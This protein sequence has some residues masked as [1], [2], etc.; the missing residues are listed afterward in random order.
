MADHSY[1]F[2]FVNEVVLPGDIVAEK[3]KTKQ[4]VVKKIKLKLG[5][6]LRM[7][8]DNI[9]AYKC[10][11]LREKDS[12]MFWIDNDQKRYIPVKNDKVV[13]IVTNRGGE[14]Y[15]VDIGSSMASAL[16]FLAF[17]GATK[18][19]KPQ[20]KI[21]DLVYGRLS[22]ANKDME[23]ELVCTDTNGKANGM[24]PLKDGFLFTH[25]LGLTRKLLN[26]D[27]AVLKVLGKVFSFESTVGLNGRT[28]VNSNSSDHTILIVNAIEQ[29]EYMTLSQIKQN[30]H[31]LA[32]GMRE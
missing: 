17:E 14:S 5:P 6:G 19:N 16:P 20:L 22:V 8:K 27:G 24:G 10:G 9:I 15:Q 30:V 25:S 4:I 11:V 28:W 12:T 26:P 13:G 18:K 21:G 3:V 29:S 7:D 23:A 31:R 32:E 2:H 1:D